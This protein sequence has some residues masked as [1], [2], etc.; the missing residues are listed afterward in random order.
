MVSRSCAVALALFAGALVNQVAS[1]VA[2]AGPPAQPAQL[3]E[4]PGKPVVERICLGCH[5]AEILFPER[6]VPV[7][8]DTLEL[9]KGFG[10]V[11]TEE[12]W[13]TIHVY[14]LSNL[15]SLNVNRAPA[16]DIAAVFLLDAEAAAGVVAHREKAGGF[17]TIDDLKKA[18]GLDAARVDAAKDRLSF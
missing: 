8:R 12:E 11:A 16:G 17:K 15:A 13:K 7:W 3:P 4:A 6:T 5:G 9:M 2:T 1:G 10:A 14:V 18:P